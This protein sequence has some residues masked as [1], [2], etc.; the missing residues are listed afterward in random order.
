MIIQAD[1]TAQPFDIWARKVYSSP[2]VEESFCGTFQ[3]DWVQLS[4][5]KKIESMW[6]FSNQST[7]RRFDV[8]IN[9]LYLT[10]DLQSTT[11]MIVL[12]THVHRTVRVMTSAIPTVVNV[13]K[14]ESDGTAV[15][16]FTFLCSHD[17]TWYN[18]INII[19]FL[20]EQDFYFMFRSF[21]QYKYQSM[22]SVPSRIKRRCDAP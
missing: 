11:W 12:V 7:F 6:V 18:K 20:E 13:R 9:I 15:V 1:E 19:Q 8:L 4:T 10:D 14:I 22:S 2:I 5:V 3:H 17:S 21:T 16:R